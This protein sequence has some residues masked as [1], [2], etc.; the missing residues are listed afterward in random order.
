MSI[1]IEI[2]TELEEYIK[3]YGKFGETHEDVLRRRIPDFLHF[4]KQQKKTR[5]RRASRTGD[6]LPQSAFLKP[7]LKVLLL[8]PNYRLPAKVAIR[9]VGKIMDLKPGDREKHMSGDIRWENNVHWN[10]NL[11]MHTKGWMGDYGRGIWGLNAV[12]VE[13]ARVLLDGET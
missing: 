4:E 10:R 5:K 12:G 1:T 13:S 6:F 7:L 11:L 3:F 8:S 9:Q 2:S